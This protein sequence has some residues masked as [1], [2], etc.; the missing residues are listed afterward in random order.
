MINQTSLKH[1][2]TVQKIK[3]ATLNCIR[4]GFSVDHVRN[5]NGQAF[6]AVRVHN[7]IA[8]VTDIHGRDVTGI[9]AAVI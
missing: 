6:L 9:V 1:P 2:V 5:S 4:N 7:G 3:S 8:Q